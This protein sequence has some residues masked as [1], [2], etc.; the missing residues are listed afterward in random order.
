MATRSK[1]SGFSLV[2]ALIASAILAVALSGLLAAFAETYR[3]TR[4]AGR[5]SVLNHLANEKLD[6]LVSLSY[7]HA[8]L[9]LGTHPTQST[10]SKGE[11]YY[12][13]AGHDENWSLRWI[14]T[15]G[16]TDGSGTA[17]ANMKTIVVEAAFATRY[18]AGG[19]AVQKP[20]SV[21]VSFRSFVAQ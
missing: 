14:V 20:T 6:E 12:A 21:N 19:V 4:Q 15:T 18:T 11:K 7:T 17:V 8:D 13:I 16:P 9:T 5:M 3:A 10:D 1:E 2:E